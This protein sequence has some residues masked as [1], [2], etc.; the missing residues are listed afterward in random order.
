M[1]RPAHGVLRRAPGCPAAGHMQTALAAAVP[2]LHR[3]TGHRAFE[4]RPLAVHD[5]LEGAHTDGGGLLGQYFNPLTGKATKTHGNTITLGGL[6]C[7]AGCAR[8]LLLSCASY[9]RCPPRNVHCSKPAYHLP[10]GAR[11]DSYYEYL[12][13]QWLLTGKQTDWLRE[14]Y[15]KAMKSVRSRRGGAAQVGCTT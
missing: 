10:A 7:C 3:I 6:P 9:V 5:R 4:D 11:S 14:R 8:R 15:V 13:K 2:R 1:L 12:L